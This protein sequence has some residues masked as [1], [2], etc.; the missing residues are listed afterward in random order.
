M[1][2]LVNLKSIG[3]LLLNAL[4]VISAYGKIV[5]FK[6]TVGSFKSVFWMKDLPE[7]LYQLTIFMV[8]VLLLAGPGAIMYSFYDKSYSQYAKYTCYALAGFTALATLLYHMPVDSNQ[9]DHKRAARIGA[10]AMSVR[11]LHMMMREEAIPLFEV[12]VAETMADAMKSEQ[13]FR[14]DNV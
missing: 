12:Q 2:E 9:I 13:E 10:A 7:F 3:A 4:F 11:F 1:Q 6:G 14:E 8:I 5:G